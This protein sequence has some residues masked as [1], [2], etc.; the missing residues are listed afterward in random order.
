MAHKTAMAITGHT[1]WQD[2]ANREVKHFLDHP[3]E[4]TSSYFMHV[5][6]PLLM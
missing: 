6:A 5:M 3:V 2:A 4:E 1:M